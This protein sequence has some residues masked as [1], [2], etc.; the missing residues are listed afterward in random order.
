MDY[1]E[2][3]GGLFRIRIR[4]SGQGQILNSLSHQM[5]DA[6]IDLRLLRFVYLNLLI[7]E[8]LEVSLLTDNQH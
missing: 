8:V 5:L 3:F 4:G 6:E 7:A 2:F 1:K